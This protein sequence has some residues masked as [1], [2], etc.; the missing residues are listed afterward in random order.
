MGTKSLAVRNS[1]R[2]TENQTATRRSGWDQLWE[3]L[4]K[5][6]LYP[7]Q[8]LEFTS[9]VLGTGGYI[10][11]TVV[12][13]KRPGNRFG[14]SEEAYSTGRL[15]RS[16]LPPQDFILSQAPDQR[17][18]APPSCQVTYCPTRS[19]Q[20]CTSSNPCFGLQHFLSVNHDSLPW[21]GLSPPRFLNAFSANSYPLS[22]VNTCQLLPASDFL[23]LPLRFLSQQLS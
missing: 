6:V 17:G 2:G 9:G 1:P 20:V 3:E 19:P 23:P 10:N 5:K 15:L 12:N 11:N 8:T 7:Q 18:S 4:S 21:Q 22:V 13:E 16:F 14:C